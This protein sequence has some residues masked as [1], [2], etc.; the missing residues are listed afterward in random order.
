MLQ[1]TIDHSLLDHLA[2]MAGAA[3]F[4]AEAART[5]TLRKMRR[6]I[7]TYIK[8]RAAKSLRIP[9]KALEGRFFST[10]LE[11]GADTLR[12][13]IGTWD[14]SPYSIG[15]PAVYGIPG[16]SGGVRVGRRLY[17]GAFLAK[18]YTTEEKV[19]IRLH[20]KHYSPELY[21]TRHRPGDR[22]WTEHRGRFPVVRAAVPVDSVIRDV[23]S[24]DGEILA[25]EF[26]KVFMQ[27][28]NYQ[29]NVKGGKA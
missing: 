15:S 19:W 29:V 16:K 4:Q 7:E 22:G 13:W 10:S 6:R 20:S 3:D 28:L 18:I 23:I 17:P 25:R 14:I 1:L 2:K 26:E 5:S 27:E 24:Q 21:P 11:P 12:V 9:Q 8:R